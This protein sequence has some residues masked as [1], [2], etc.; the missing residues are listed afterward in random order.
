MQCRHTVS[1]CDALTSLF[2]RSADTICLS[3][4]CAASATGEGLCA[5]TVA[6]KNGQ[7]TTAGDNAYTYEL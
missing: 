3:P 2:S 1:L 5:P 7:N 4:R 6:V